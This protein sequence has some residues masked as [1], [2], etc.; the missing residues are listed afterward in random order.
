MTVRII[1]KRYLN[2]ILALASF[3]IAWSTNFS[4]IVVNIFA[5]T[6]VI[7]N[8]IRK[9]RIPFSN[10]AFP[11]KN[12]LFSLTMFPIINLISINHYIP[13]IQAYTF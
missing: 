7:K 12:T 4:S 9:P 2:G 3:F 1:F 8:V 11:N 13:Y 5:I 10:I 6:T